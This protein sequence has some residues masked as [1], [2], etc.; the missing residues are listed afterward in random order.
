MSEFSLVGMRPGCAKQ[1]AAAR[2]EVEEQT[3][4]EFGGID[5]SVEE[6]A[7]RVAPEQRARSLILFVF[8]QG[9]TVSEPVGDCATG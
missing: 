6:R 5:L 1:T 9:R 3:G 4:G 2:Q 8:P 7:A